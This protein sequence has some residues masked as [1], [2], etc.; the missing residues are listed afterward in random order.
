VIALLNGYYS[1]LIIVKSLGNASDAVIAE[2]IG[3]KNAWL[4]GKNK[5]AAR[6]HTME[7]LERCIGWLHVYDMKAKG[8]NSS[9][10]D[11]AF[12]IELLDHLLYPGK[13][14]VFNEN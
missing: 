11:Y 6:R 13:E 2:A 3:N 7:N 9:A 1:N 14:P 5:E 8:W 4:I 12:T 10:D